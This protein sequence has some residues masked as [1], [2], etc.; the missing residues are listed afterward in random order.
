MGCASSRELGDITEKE[1]H[2]KMV[3]VNVERRETLARL[4]QI[5]E[6]SARGVQAYKLKKGAGLH[7]ANYYEY[8]DRKRR[9]PA[10][11]AEARGKVRTV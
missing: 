4:R 8:Q 11:E 1:Y 5:P 10:R 7:E 3:K 9:G 6:S 2:A